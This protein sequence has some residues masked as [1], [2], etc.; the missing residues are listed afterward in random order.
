MGRRGINTRKGILRATLPL[1]KWLPVRKGL[2]LIGEFGRWEYHLA[3]KT[4]SQFDEAIARHA[5]ILGESWDPKVVGP[6]LAA[7]Q[8]R[9]RARDLLLDGRTDAQLE[10]VFH[11]EGRDLLDEA[12]AK[13]KGVLLLGNHFGAHLLM[14]YWMI[15][16]GYQWRMFGER[17]RHISKLM[18]EQFALEGP[19]GQ[20]RLFVS[21]RTNPAEAAGAIL[22]AA[23]VLKG[24]IVLSIASDVRWPTPPNAVASFLGRSYAFSSTW[25]TLAAHSGA[26]VVPA[27][28]SIERDGT[29]RVEFEPGFVIPPGAA[30]DEG[31]SAHWVQHGLDLIED[32]VR[33]DPANSIDYFFWEE[34]EARPRERLAG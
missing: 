1:V 2:S 13:G 15:R 18:A 30:R 27:Y 7:N 22:R 9:S 10:G 23:R 14:A 19:L 20:T 17:P 26:P 31:L 11:V 4:R 12:V 5:A 25:V 34:D 33:R 24:G 28:C 21:R 8:I 6:E 29:Y 3:P 32:R 16:H